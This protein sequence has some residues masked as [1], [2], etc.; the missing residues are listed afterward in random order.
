MQI[1]LRSWEE[2]PL[3]YYR[4]REAVKTVKKVM[5]QFELT[6]EA[7]ANF[8]PGFEEREPWGTSTSNRRSNP[9]GFAKHRTLSGFNRSSKS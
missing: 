2:T 8:S 5:M 9:E 7:L 4:S 3:T 1:S 6:P